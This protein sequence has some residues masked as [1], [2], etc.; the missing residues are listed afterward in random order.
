MTSIAF[1]G[2]GIMGA[3]MARRLCEAGHTVTAWNRTRVKD[4][5]TAI[6]TARSLDLDLPVSKLV[7]SLYEDMIAHGDGEIDRSGPYRELQRRNG[8]I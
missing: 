4:C 5:R 7:E 6:R 1:L 8:L 2:I 3:Q